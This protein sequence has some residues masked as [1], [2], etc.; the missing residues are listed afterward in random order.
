MIYGYNFAGIQ[1]QSERKT[2]VS[3]KEVLMMLFG[4]PSPAISE[5][6]SSAES[7]GMRTHCVR[8]LKIFLQRPHV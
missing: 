8:Y 5:S 2:Y 1:G 6:T 3:A 7:F 4:S